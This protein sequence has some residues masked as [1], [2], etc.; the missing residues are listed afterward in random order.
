MLR[1]FLLIIV[2]FGLI[3]NNAEA[4]SLEA[5]K[6]MPD[7]SIK[8]LEGKYITAAT[9]KNRILI[10]NL[11]ATWCEPCRKEMPAI[12]A[13]YKKYHEQGVDVI[14]VS[15]DEPSDFD[16]VKQFSS[17]FAF[18]VALQKDSD[19]QNLGR[20]W[21]VPVTFIIDQNGILRRNGWKGD[22]LIDENILEKN[23]APLLVP[24]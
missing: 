23:V 4:A 21:R 24:Q 3:Y 18:P 17:A 7:F 20:I 16:K 13:F 5:G 14:A 10:I 6:P 1:I 19:L 15:V 2:L 22:P 9:S 11:W 12:D 8:T